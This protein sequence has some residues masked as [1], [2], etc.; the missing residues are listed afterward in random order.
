MVEG[1]S[2]RAAQQEHRALLRFAEA[3]AIMRAPTTRLE[4]ARSQ[5]ALGRLV[6]AQRT[7]RSIDGAA[8]T[9]QEPTAFA[10]AREGAAALLQELD[11]R[12]PIV[13]VTFKDAEEGYAA[14]VSVDG[15]EV[16][17]AVLL[18]G[19]RLDPGSHVVTARSGER[20]STQR[21]SLVEGE[22]RELVLELP[23]PSARAAA[24]PEPR[25]SSGVS[26]GVYVLGGV[27]LASLGAGT[28]LLLLEE[29]DKRAPSVA[30]ALGAAAAT[31]AVVWLLLEREPATKPE[32]AAWSVG[33]GPAWGGAGVDLRARF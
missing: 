29:N 3:D 1:R 23:A 12:I 4:V 32:R 8:S 5:A 15:V 7:A 16:P 17:A 24:T 9:E 30:F 10:R 18:S 11:R 19:Y 20:S 13:Q 31:G 27:A 28:A 26:P 22:R 25:A 21:L 14:H 2:A 33:L 6:E